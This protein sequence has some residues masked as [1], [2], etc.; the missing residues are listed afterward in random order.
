MTKNTSAKRIVPIHDKL[1][2]LGFL[3]YIN[4]LKSQNIERVFPQLGE[5]KRGYGVP[6]GKKFSN[7][8]FRKEW[9]NLEEIEANGETKVF[10]NFRH[11]FI[12]KVKSSNKPQMVDHLVGHKT[13]NYNYEHIS[14][15]D[16]A[17]SVNQLN[18]DDIDFSHIIKYID[19]N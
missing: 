2:E 11:N 13:G 3:D 12:T 10:H 18:Y 5:N 16:L 4:K 9:L 7:H 19:E 6:F 17:D 8:N 14:L 15:Y 1:I